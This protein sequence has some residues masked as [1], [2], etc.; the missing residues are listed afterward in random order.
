MYFPYLRA[1]QYDLAAIFEVKDSTYKNKSVIPVIEPVTKIVEKHYKRILEKGIHFI[2]VT[3]PMVGDLASVSFSKTI[4]D[5]LVTN[6]F[7]DYENYTLGFII[8]PDTSLADVKTFITRFPNN[9]HAFIHFHKF[10]DATKLAEIISADKNNKYNIFID[11]NIGVDYVEEFSSSK[12][13]DI[14]ISDGF[15]KRSKNEAY[16]EEDFFYDLHNR[17]AIDLN[18]NGFGDFTIIGAQ[19]SKGGGPAYVVAIHLT[20][21]DKHNNLVVKH[22]KSDILSPP[23]SVDPGGKFNQALKRLKKHLD[24]TSHLNTSGVDEYKDLHTTGHYPGLGIVKKISIKH[25]IEFIHSFL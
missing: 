9:E 12:A 15:K 1:K 23:S 11:G 5:S 7:K 16:P 6:V 2:L 18:Y 21:K 8:Q 3:N 19:F 4:I 17:Y 25:H 10:N 22:F 24:A 13:P 20:D 14:L